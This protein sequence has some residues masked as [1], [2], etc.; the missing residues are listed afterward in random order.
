MFGGL[1]K[2][3][4]GLVQRKKP[5]ASGY[6]HHGANTTKKSLLGWISNSYGAHEDIDRN[7]VKLRERS[8]DLYMGGA[9]IATGALK[10]MRTNVI[11]AGLTVKPSIMGDVLGI[12]SEESDAW[13]RRAQTEFDLWASSVDC[14]A[15][16]QN[17]FSDLQQLAFLSWLMDGDVFV[18]LPYIKRQG[19]PYD[20]RVL[21]IEVMLMAQEKTSSLIP[22]WTMKANRV[23]NDSGEDELL[24]EV[25]IYGDISEDPQWWDELTPKTFR[26]SLKLLGDVKRID[27]HINSYG[28]FVSAGAAIYSILKQQTA[29]VVVHIDGFALSAASVIAMA[30]DT[31]VM[32][33]NAVIMIHNPSIY[34]VGDANQLR[35]DADTLDKLREAMVAAYTGKTGLSR[36]EII[37]MLDAETWLTADEAV[38]KGFADVV[39]EPL[40][41]V[42]H[43]K[44]NVIAVNGQVF[45]LSRYKKP[46]I[47]LLKNNEMEGNDLV[48]K[49][50]THVTPDA[51]PASQPVNQETTAQTI[52]PTAETIV[53]ATDRDAI[54]AEAVASE[55]AR[56]AALDELAVPGA[57]DLIAQAKQS[58][59]LPH[60]V[61]IEIIK[62][63]KKPG[64]VAFNA[65]QADAANSGVN[66]LAAAATGDGI[67]AGPGDNPAAALNSEI[68]NRRG[69][70]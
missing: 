35:K 66:N 41:A 68:R 30:G 19:S 17:D 67:G 51:N 21:L 12:S 36:D 70:K 15:A 5:T 43:V 44:A 32:P 11:G 9:L 49:D 14:D 48:N 3:V 37:E 40:M 13:Q 8:R 6:S 29:E 69:I 58:G 31:V 24:G 61:A 55:R 16:R 59:A 52:A 26:E 1:I 53:P 60:D 20:L 62:A 63:Q 10:T 34:S 7:I 33:G 57:E 38:E 28:G 23:K 56:L 64:T 4:K 54:F 65:R 50:K 39:A 45:D 2:R 25:L 47:S 18:A 27:V 22:F 46:P 42:A